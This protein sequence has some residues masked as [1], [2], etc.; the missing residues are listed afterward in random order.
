MQCSTV[1]GEG[2]LCDN[3]LNRYRYGAGVHCSHGWYEVVMDTRWTKSGQL[4]GGSGEAH[5][6]LKIE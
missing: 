4:L 3:P 6:S 5:R 2:F 1:N